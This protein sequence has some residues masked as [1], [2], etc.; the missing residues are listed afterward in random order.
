MNLQRI[1]DRDYISTLYAC[2][3]EVK[4]NS[5]KIEAETIVTNLVKAG[6]KPLKVEN[7]TNGVLVGFEVAN[8]DEILFSKYRK[9][10]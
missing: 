5:L 6:N 2:F 1:P 3:A 10:I 9:Q 8:G 7:R 4:D